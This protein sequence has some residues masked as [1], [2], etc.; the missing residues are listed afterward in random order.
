MVVD[1][2]DLPSKTGRSLQRRRSEVGVTSSG[3]KA[4]IALVLIQLDD[5]AQIHQYERVR[6]MTRR[7]GHFHG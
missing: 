7:G 6:A 2:Q 3:R 1:L 5:V 4:E